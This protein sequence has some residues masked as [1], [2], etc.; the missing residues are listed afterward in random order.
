MVFSSKIAL[1]SPKI[2]LKTAIFY[3]FPLKG[4]FLL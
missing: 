4:K 2:A 1:K 3:I